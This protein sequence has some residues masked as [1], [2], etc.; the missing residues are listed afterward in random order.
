[1]ALLQPIDRG[2]L[3]AATATKLSPRHSILASLHACLAAETLLPY[4]VIDPAERQPQGMGCG[5][6]ADALHRYWLRQCRPGG[7]RQVADR[8]WAL[9][10]M[11][12]TG[13]VVLIP[14]QPVEA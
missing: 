13:A 12:S 10:T 9:R 2:I 1:M 5:M 3:I 4:L 7:N 8:A 11:L 6:I 14:T